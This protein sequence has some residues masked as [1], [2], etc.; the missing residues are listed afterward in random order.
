[1][2]EAEMNADDRVMSSRAFVPEE[3]T[4]CGH[5]QKGFFLNSAVLHTCK[6]I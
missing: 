4:T 3:I 6:Y 2:P 1:M 5:F